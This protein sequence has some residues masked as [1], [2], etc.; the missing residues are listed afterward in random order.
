MAKVGDVQ[1]R[2]SIRRELADP[3]YRE[4]LAGMKAASRQIGNSADSKL[5]WVV[6]FAAESP[7]SWHPAA[8]VAFGDCLL[9]LARWRVPDNVIHGGPMPEPLPIDE[10]EELQHELHRLLHRVVNSAVGELVHVV[11]VDQLEINIVR[12]SGKGSKPAVWG[13]SSRA[14]ST[15]DALLHAVTNLIVTAGARLV[16]CHACTAP[17]I[18][19]G[20]RT[21]C[22]DSGCAQRARNE[23][24]AARARSMT[25]GVA[26]GKQTRKK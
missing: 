25:K 5:A 12:A 14:A 23:R 10:V 9:A 22:R 18:G 7:S 20:K 3:G 11:T 1:S 6:R 21:H 16:A 19:D 26:S 24:R 13:V 2:E 17:L 8:V 4:R 15:R